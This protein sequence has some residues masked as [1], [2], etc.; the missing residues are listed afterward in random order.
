MM[1]KYLAI[2]IVFLGLIFVALS[3]RDVITHSKYVK[4]GDNIFNVVVVDTLE[5]RSKGLSGKVSLRK[6][7]GM[8]FIFDKPA[9]YSF[10]MKD[11]NFPIDIIWIDENFRI[12][13][14]KE[15]AHPNSY[16]KSFIPKEDALYV[17]EV[18][19]GTVAEEKIKISN[20]L[21]IN[22]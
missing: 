20:S 2:F 15:S 22:F 3:L 13:D 16:P 4:I 5:G 11:M 10:W 19:A 18:D 12:V 1:K 21:Y 8:L 6:N 9:K 14:I 17:L 7:E